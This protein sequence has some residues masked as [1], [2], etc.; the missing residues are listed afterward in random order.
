M[1]TLIDTKMNEFPLPHIVPYDKDYYIE[2]NEYFKRYLNHVKN[3]SNLNQECF[4]KTKR[5]VDLIINSLS[6]YNN[7]RIGEAKKCIKKILEDY[8]DQPYIISALDKNYAFRGMAP[9]AIQPKVFGYKETYADKYKKMN[10]HPLSFFKARVAV[11][12]IKKKD[13][14]HIPFDKRG[15][16][17]T[18]RFS[19]A[20]VPCLYVATT[21]FGCW[22]EM[23]MPEP[24]VFQ[25]ASYK[26]PSDL[27]VLNLCISQYTINEGRYLD[28][29]ELRDL[30]SLIEIFPL[31]CATSFKVQEMNRSFKSEYIVS[32]LLMQVT[33]E[34]DI[35]GIAYLS[36]K[37]EDSHAYPQAVN[38]A[39]SITCDKFPP[40]S[41]KLLE[42]YWKDAHKIKLSDAFRFSQFLRGLQNETNH[43][44][45]YLSYLNEIFY[46]HH[47]NKVLLAG[48]EIKYTET[49]FSEFDEFLVNQ[50]HCE[51][52]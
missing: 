16:I 15:L 33:N 25:V 45:P 1:G 2:L 10:E 17:T 41:E 26:L 40:Y 18:Q 7:A 21:S 11:E 36:K 3:I 9:K 52:K 39:I 51:F 34:L 37:M 49:K 28:D 50:E 5:N 13:M 38:L 12:S 46:D 6:F 20:G 14:L 4:N 35:G 48:K 19:I 31:V 32:Q 47:H 8:Y 29:D 22:L 24:D 27:K 23:E 30:Y 43:K 42:M 44:P